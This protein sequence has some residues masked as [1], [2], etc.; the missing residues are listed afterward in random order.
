MRPIP[1]ARRLLSETV[2]L[3]GRTYQEKVTMITDS[4]KHLSFLF[5][6]ADTHKCARHIGVLNTSTALETFRF[7]MFFSSHD[8][9]ISVSATRIE[10]DCL[11]C[12]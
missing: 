5:D 12:L 11:S 4:P 6:M 7:T 1:F 9:G 10:I 3:L 8:L 2:D